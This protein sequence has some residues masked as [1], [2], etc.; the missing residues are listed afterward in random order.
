[1]PDVTIQEMY[2]FLS[3]TVQMGHDQRDI[4]KSY[5]SELEQFLCPFTETQGKRQI[6]YTEISIL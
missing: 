1:L 2:C 3:V 5:W 4:M 6:S